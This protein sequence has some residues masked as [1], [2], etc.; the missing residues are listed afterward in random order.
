MGRKS[1]NPVKEYYN[2]DIINN[3]AA[4]K[5]D[6]CKSVMKSITS[7]NLESHIKSC[8]PMTYKELLESKERLNVNTN[9]SKSLFPSKRKNEGT[10]LTLDQ[11]SFCEN[12]KISISISK[13]ELVNAC[14]QL[15]TENGLPYTFVE[16]PGFQKIINPIIEGLGGK[17]AINSSNI[18]EKVVDLSNSIKEKIKK[19][20]ENRILSIKIDTA[21]K[22]G[23]SI[24]GIYIF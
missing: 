3:N 18:K 19:E 14:V 20:I 21:S 5:I 22:N 6:E 1:T 24:I 13:K 15:I 16:Y 8:H 2:I 4:C 12:K 11:I 10:Q 7:S 23:R 17:F 9:P